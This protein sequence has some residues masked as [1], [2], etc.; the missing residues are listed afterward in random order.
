MCFRRRKKKT[1]T[2]GISKAICSN[3]IHKFNDKK[4]EKQ[5]KIL[6]NRKI[7]SHKSQEN[8]FGVYAAH[9]EMICRHLCT[10]HLLLSTLLPCLY[11]LAFQ[12]EFNREWI[13][14]FFYT[15]FPLLEYEL[16]DLKSQ[17]IHIATI[18]VPFST[19]HPND[20]MLHVITCEIEHDFCL[21]FFQALEVSLG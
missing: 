6:K 18:F 13:F 17:S 2:K 20:S 10:L 21:L 19:Q 5:N 14:I 8:L 1:E 7:H 3:R 15:L 11:P 9:S 4:I 12:T 16:S